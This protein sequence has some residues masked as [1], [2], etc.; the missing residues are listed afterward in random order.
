MDQNVLD[1]YN[2]YI[3][4][5][6]KPAVNF[7]AALTG[8]PIVY[9]SLKRFDLIQ[10]NDE[11]KE[12]DP[13]DRTQKE[14]ESIFDYN[15]RR[16]EILPTKNVLK[17]VYTE[18]V[19]LDPEQGVTN[20]KEPDGLTRIQIDE[21]YDYYRLRASILK[22]NQTKAYLGMDNQLQ[23]LLP[24]LEDIYYKKN[25]KVVFQYNNVEFVYMVKEQPE[26][27]LNDIFLLQINLINS[28]S[29]TA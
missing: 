12:I 11:Y 3:S 28:N 13:L 26:T 23:I 20:I 7:N 6:S 15:E 2:D 29:I 21:D 5:I 9:C 1:N 25:D 14:N 16:N 19:N 24:K 17:N 18:S 22:S 10:E 4:H 27:Y 8:R